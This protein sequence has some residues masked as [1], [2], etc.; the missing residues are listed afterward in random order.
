MKQQTFHNIHRANLT[1]LSVPA[2]VASPQGGLVR[3][4][5]QDAGGH[6]GGRKVLAEVKIHAS[7]SQVTRFE[8]PS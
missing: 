4:F 2:A 3:L 5:Q 7:V 1:C 6:L 8:L